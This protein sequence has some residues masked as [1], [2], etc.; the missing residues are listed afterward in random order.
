MPPYCARN[1]FTYST[2]AKKKIIEYLFQIDVEYQFPFIQFLISYHLP[3]PELKMLIEKNPMVVDSG[4][5][6]KLPILLAMA[7]EPALMSYIAEV[8]FEHSV[9]SDMWT[10]VMKVYNQESFLAYLCLHNS[11]ISRGILQTCFRKA[12]FTRLDTINSGVNIQ[13]EIVFSVALAVTRN[14]HERRAYEKLLHINPITLNQSF[15]E[16]ECGLFEGGISPLFWKRA[17]EQHSLFSFLPQKP[18]SQP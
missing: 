2:E 18:R 10:Q 9:S 11:R 14:H 15:P 1:Y 6:T 12:E 5:G 4:S 17:P 8:Y 3:R 13:G 16:T 7:R